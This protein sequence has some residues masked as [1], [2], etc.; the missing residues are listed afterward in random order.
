MSLAKSNKNMLNAALNKSFIVNSASNDDDD[1]SSNDGE[2]QAAVQAPHSGGTE[3]EKIMEEML[4]MAKKDMAEYQ[5]F[6]ANKKANP[7]KMF[8]PPHNMSS[9]VTTLR[10]TKGVA[11]RFF[12]K[13]L[14]ND[15]AELAFET[16][17][18]WM[19]A[20]FFYFKRENND[21]NMLWEFVFEILNN[22]PLCNEKDEREEGLMTMDTFLDKFGPIP[23]LMRFR[24]FFEKNPNETNKNNYNKVNSL[25]EKWW[26]IYEND[27]VYLPPKQKV[28]PKKPYELAI[29]KTLKLT[30][31]ALARKK[32]RTVIPNVTDV[33]H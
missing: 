17:K 13:A 11:R 8:I 5:T 21:A 2:E 27:R 31:P 33:A 18:R 15:N 3:K 4:E 12:L 25:M 24:N 29:R 7:E 9:A 6:L 1:N 28:K 26:F 10:N 32:T 19:L 22:I 20:T 30:N 23:M 16:L 14:L